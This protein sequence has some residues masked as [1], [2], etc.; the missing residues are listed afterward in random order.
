MFDWLKRRP[1]IPEGMLQLTAFPVD[2]DGLPTWNS[3]LETLTSRLGSEFLR[4][5]LFETSPGMCIGGFVAKSELRTAVRTYQARAT[6][7]QRKNDEFRTTIIV[8]APKTIASDGTAWS[9]C[10][11][12]SSTSVKAVN[13]IVPL[14]RE[15]CQNCH[16]KEAQAISNSKPASN[17]SGA[18][19]VKGGGVLLDHRV[20]RT[21]AWSKPGGAHAMLR[22]SVGLD[23]FEA[24]QIVRRMSVNFA[25]VRLPLETTLVMGFF[26][27]ELK[28]GFVEV[29]A[30]PV[31]EEYRDEMLDIVMHVH[32]DDIPKCLDAFR[33][34][35]TIQ[36][37][38]AHAPQPP[39]PPNIGSSSDLLA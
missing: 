22:I 14:L 35:S 9:A 21:Y 4:P 32:E 13:D 34:G 39:A 17:D 1:G 7:I 30:L 16:T 36:F 38:L 15:F 2:D 3:E 26:T 6:M 37:I 20:V 11:R 29:Q 23:S 10:E 5:F 12:K 24:N 28:G 18:W 31:P 8:T 19:A 33:A 27:E 25:S